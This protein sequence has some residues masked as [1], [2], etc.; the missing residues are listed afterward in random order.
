MIRSA[1]AHGSKAMARSRNSPPAP[2]TLFAY[3][4][5]SHAPLYRAV[6]R[7]F[8]E[9]KESYRIQLR[10]G[11]LAGA[12]SPEVIAAV[13]SG[14]TETELD[15]SVLDRALDQLVRWGNLRRSHDTGRVTTLEDF[16]RRHH[17]YQ[18]TPAGEEAERAVGRVLDALESSGSL[19][20]VMLEEIAHNLA[21]LADLVDPATDKVEDPTAGQLYTALFNVGQ[22][23]QALTENASTFLTRLHEALDE[24]AL[25]EQTFS[26]YKQAVIQ[27]VDQFV[28]DL[29]RLA[30]KIGA[31]IR[32]IEE[33]GAPEM[34][35]LAASADIAPTADGSRGRSAALLR[36]WRG[37]VSWFLGSE[38]ELPTAD[39]LRGAA[40]AAIVR[41]LVVVERLHEKQFRRVDRTADLLRL[42][43]WFEQL[44]RLDDG[45]ARAHRLYLSAFGLFGARH[46][47]GLHDDPE[48]ISTGA[49]WW[50]APP[51]PVPP[52][53][54]KL[55]KTSVLGRTAQVVDHSETRRFLAERHRR[56][57]EARRQTLSRFVDRGPIRL[58]SLPRLRNDEFDLLLELLD[59]LYSAA[60][61]TSRGTRTARSRD[62][63][64]A[65][66][67]EPQATEATAHLAG[68]R[69]TLAV[70]D[71]CL[72]VTSRTDVK[73]P[74]TTAAA[75]RLGR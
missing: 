22:Q 62:G 2:L 52:V 25:D 63:L 37:V 48:L 15:R 3:T 55:G 28:S 65:L 6:M 46:L 43:S 12:L 66:R 39:S 36:Q 42:A 11:E 30:P 1:F 57:R 27:Y 71:A 50:Q 9:A 18:L 20:R 38:T 19:Q 72:E 45:A 35:A 47:G 4:S 74:S 34:V 16:R 51:V 33:A 44:A 56:E 29:S 69:G 61:A 13:T 32:R 67:L 7:Y 75:G 5:E 68:P 73:I 8:L 31:D 60:P 54:R 14:E 40:R 21:R 10:P 70:P 49:S 26:L 58:S 53:L 41:I 23:F 64:L 59:R 24:G 17:V